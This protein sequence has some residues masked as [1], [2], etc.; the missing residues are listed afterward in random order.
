[1]PSFDCGY[2]MQQDYIKKFVINESNHDEEEEYG[3]LSLLW[4]I[5]DWWYHL[6][7]DIRSRTPLPDIY[8]PDRKSAYETGVIWFRT[9]STAAEGIESVSE[10]EAD[11]IVKRRFLEA[12]GADF[13]E[14]QL[15]FF[16]ISRS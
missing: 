12:I 11:R 6:E 1:M 14:N 3:S 8:V 5:R 9:R 4:D 7:R 2:F 15:V 13:V 16:V 10:I